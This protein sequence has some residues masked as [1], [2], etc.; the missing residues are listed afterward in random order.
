MPC[1]L[2]LLHLDERRHWTL[3]PATASREIPCHV[4]VVAW[5]VVAAKLAYGLGAATATG[6]VD[7]ATPTAAPASGGPS[8]TH[9]TTRE[10]MLRS[11]TQ[12][13]GAELASEILFAMDSDAA[14]DA[15]DDAD[16]LTDSKDD[17]AAALAA[18]TRTGAGA[19]DAAAPPDARL[20]DRLPP[21]SQWRAR[22]APWFAGTAPVASSRI[23]WHDR[24]VVAARASAASPNSCVK[25]CTLIARVP[26]DLERMTPAA[27]RE[28]TAFAATSIVADAVITARTSSVPCP[29]PRPH[30]RL[31]LRP[32]PRLRLRP[33]PCPHLS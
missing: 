12:R 6:P 32:R 18:Q 26:S 21:W 24:S 15:M 11:L 14:S 3:N 25:Q 30:P 4:P 13:L 29:R 33:R 28:Y 5:V 8:T 23:P 9:V 16:A 2:R 20:A 19:G 10:R 22:V 7:G 31:R 27:V 17:V 1:A